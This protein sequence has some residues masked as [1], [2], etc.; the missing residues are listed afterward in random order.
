MYRRKEKE[1]KCMKGKR[2]KGSVW[3]N[4]DR[5]GMYERKEKERKCIEGK[6]MGEM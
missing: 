5:K 6:R 1:K 4:R 3:K 2:K